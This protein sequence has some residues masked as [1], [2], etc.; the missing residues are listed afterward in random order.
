MAD[1][2]PLCWSTEVPGLRA[3]VPGPQDCRTPSA[4]RTRELAGLT[5][6]L[7]AALV[8]SALGVRQS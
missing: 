8:R 5:M 2:A 1:Q 4:D 7:H 3:E 6:K